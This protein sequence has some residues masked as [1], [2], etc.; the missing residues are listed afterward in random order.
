VTWRLVVAGRQ[1]E[2]VSGDVQSWPGGRVPTIG[3]GGSLG[4]RA[5]ARS[6]VDPWVVSPDGR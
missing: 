3:T 5:R 1:T 4:H 6:M 2:Q